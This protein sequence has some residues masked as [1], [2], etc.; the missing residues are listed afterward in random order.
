M[1][2]DKKKK[3]ATT[4]FKPFYS[5]E[6]Q[7]EKQPCNLF[8]LL[9]LSIN[10]ITRIKRSMFHTPHPYR[11]LPYL[12]GAVGHPDGKTSR[13]DSS[14]KVGEVPER[15][16]GMKHKK[17]DLSYQRDCP[18]AESPSSLSFSPVSPRQNEVCQ[19]H[20]T[21]FALPPVP[22][23]RTGQRFRHHRPH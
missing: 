10:V 6:K 15:R 11:E 14:P 22:S 13:R 8:N 1:G 21:Q 17:V 4:T 5:E 7:I 19:K 3:R 12:R 2:E 20:R 16:R 23:E 18:N 9:I